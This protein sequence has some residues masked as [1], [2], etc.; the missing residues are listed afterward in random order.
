MH[1]PINIC[2]NQHC[3]QPIYKGDQVWH[4]GKDLYCNLGCLV[5]QMKEETK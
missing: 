3:E 1:K 4:R 5:Q 2:T